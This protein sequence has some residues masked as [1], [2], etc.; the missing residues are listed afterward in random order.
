MTTPLQKQKLTR[1]FKIHDADGH[2]FVE[3]ADFERIIHNFVRFCKLESNPELQQKISD[4]Y[5]KFWDDLLR[6]ADNNDDSQIDLEEWLEYH[7]DML[8]FTT[9][10]SDPPW[11]AWTEFIFDLLDV[12]QDGCWSPADYRLFF[13]IYEMDDFLADKVFAQ[14]D[15]NG[16]GHIS[17]DE[18]LQLNRDFYLSSKPDVPGNH[19]FGPLD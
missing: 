13:R 18:F 19:F 3:N 10:D 15:L 16:D 2:G 12:D 9:E 7:S 11:L 8:S 6:L 1:L 14:I 5:K 17:Q 4:Q